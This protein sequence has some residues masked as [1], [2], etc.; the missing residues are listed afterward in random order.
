MIQKVNYNIME[1]V[2]KNMIQTQIN[3]NYNQIQLLKNYKINHLIILNLINC[4]CKQKLNAK[5]I[6][7]QHQKKIKKQ[8]NRS[9]NSNVK[10][11][12]NIVRTLLHCQFKINDL[13]PKTILKLKKN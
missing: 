8:K 1:S 9:V 12:L 2:N 7:N 5:M 3:K 10:M 11:I 4:K 6:Q 13:F